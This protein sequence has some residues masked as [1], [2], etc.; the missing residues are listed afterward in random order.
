M[1]KKPSCHSLCI[2]HHSK[3]SNLDNCK[4][5]I[6]GGSPRRAAMFSYD[7]FRRNQWVLLPRDNHLYGNQTNESSKQLGRLKRRK[8]KRKGCEFM[9]LLCFDHHSKTSNFDNRK[10]SIP[11]G[12][13]RRA[14]MFSYD[15]FRR[16]QWVL[17]PRD[18]HLYGN[19]TSESSK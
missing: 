7:A 15:A 2:D 14:A 18:N 8:T 6:P 19:Q 9:H 16:N 11:G 1:E 3:T 13:P 5:S 4:C 17:L 10:S 12:S